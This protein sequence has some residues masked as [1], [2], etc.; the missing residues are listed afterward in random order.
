MTVQRKKREPRTAFNINITPSFREY[1][2]GIAK[3]NGIRF[4]ELIRIGVILFLEKY[5]PSANLT[6]F[7]DYQDMKSI[8]EKYE[9]G[10]ILNND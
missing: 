7:E 2:K 5:E 3:K 6:I 9:I 8:A 10:E 4:S 1:I